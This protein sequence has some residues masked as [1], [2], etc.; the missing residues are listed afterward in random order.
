MKKKLLSLLLAFAM[1]A[2]LLPA[3]RQDA[4]AEE[5]TCPWQGS[6]TEEDPYQIG[7][8]AD[9]EALARRVNTI[10]MSRPAFVNQHFIL[11]AD[12]GSL[13]AEGNPV[14]GLTFP[15]GWYVLSANDGAKFGGTFDGNG[16]TVVVDM[17][18]NQFI[19][20]H[21]V[22]GQINPELVK[23]DMGP[24]FY[25]PLT[26][27]FGL[28]GFVKDATIQNLTV[29]G[30]VGGADAVAGIVACS[31]GVTLLD[32]TNKAEVHPYPAAEV[33][34][35]EA[36]PLGCNAGGLLGKETT[37][38]GSVYME[39][40]VNEGEVSF[41]TESALSEFCHGNTAFII[42]RTKGIGGLVGLCQS[43]DCINCRNSGDVT[44]QVCL[45]QSGV[46]GIVGELHS[47]FEHP[48]LLN[49]LNE[50]DISGNVCVGGLVGVGS[51]ARLTN[52][53]NTGDVTAVAYPI[54][55][56]GIQLTGGERAGGLAGYT[57]FGFRAENCFNLG[58]VTAAS[59]SGQLFGFSDNSTSTS[60]CLYLDTAP[61]A[62]CGE[63]SCGSDSND[64]ISDALAKESGEDGLCYKLNDWIDNFSEENPGY[65][66]W[67]LKEV[68]AY[69]S[70]GITYHKHTAGDR[71]GFGFPLRNGKPMPSFSGSYYLTEDVVLTDQWDIDDNVVINLCLNGHALVGCGLS[72]K[73]VIHANDSKL[74]VFD[75]ETNGVI[76]HPGYVDDG[77]LWHLDKD[78]AHVV[79]PGEESLTVK[80]GIITGGCHHGICL[81][82]GDM[83]LHG[84]TV[85]G[86]TVDDA[87]EPF[88]G[89]IYITHDG[90]LTIYDGAVSYNTVSVQ[91]EK[92]CG[93][94]IDVGTRGTVKLYDG[95]ISHNT[96]QNGGGL[97]GSEDKNGAPPESIYFYLYGGKITD[98][99]ALGGTGGG[100]CANIPS[101]EGGPGLYVGGSVRITGNVLKEELSDPAPTRNNVY[102]KNDAQCPCCIVIDE[103]VAPV[104]ED[105]M[106]GVHNVPLAPNGTFTVVLQN[107]TADDVYCMFA[108]FADESIRFV[109]GE[110]TTGKIELYKHAHNFAYTA[111]GATLTATCTPQQGET[112][113]IPDPHSISL[114]LTA[115][116]GTY[117]GEPFTAAIAAGEKQK[118]ESQGLTVPT[119]VYCTEDSEELNAAPVEVGK[120]IAMITA[121]DA[122]AQVPFEIKA[123]STGGGGGGYDGSKTWNTEEEQPLPV[124][125]D[126]PVTAYYAPAVSWAVESAITEGTDAT[127][128][129]PN[130]SVTRAQVVTFLWR[131]AGSPAVDAGTVT[132]TDVPADAYYAEAVR[133]ALANGVTRGVTETEFAPNVTC[134]R[135]QIVTLLARYN[136]IKDANAKTNFTDVAEDAYY[137]AAVSWAV[138]KGVT[139]GETATAFA[140]HEACTRAQT[141]TFLYRLA[142]AE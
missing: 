107:A 99:A 115:E 8:L 76:E 67:E 49:C 14:S 64:K 47:T 142:M 36:T 1:L 124:F 65:A 75:C 89:G 126:V 54:S 33:L 112:C 122:T 114:T 43:L 111:E 31:R 77:G 139:S 7:T 6:G 120:Y 109:P 93:G 62:E 57:S 98:N 88:G 19:E 22:G 118:W 42:A 131:A 66:K 134:T 116:S 17:D 40:C 117:T 21:K 60:H 87:E 5:W 32:C 100:I 58:N 86:N 68:G 53:G 11:T 92:A 84:G 50:G 91:I 46:G 18:L 24:N 10:G 72:D 129:S 79:S 106:I 27:G 38:D 59:K 48:N 61:I 29:A 113:S 108:D 2:T 135:A 45:Y 78:Q 105:M 13:D 71:R 23:A 141:V 136:G 55:S 74:N 119:I 12:I 52:C 121:G 96:A 83:T 35:G 51:P 137:A 3:V 97:G 63:G 90:D 101:N 34:I 41:L 103:S 69:P 102:L 73:S 140:P 56:G 81:D 16:H 123:V 104:T 85:I 26:F 82:S 37:S 30:S 44:V 127:H 20:N 130:A 25:W 15:I 9:L 95:E 28:F 80:G 125:V 94:G 39:N 128:F 132:M 110:G 4:Y 70:H 138:G 133:W